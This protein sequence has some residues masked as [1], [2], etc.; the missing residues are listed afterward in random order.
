MRKDE[1]LNRILFSSL[2]VSYAY[3]LL[4][5]IPYIKPEGKGP[6]WVLI[7]M[8][9]VNVGIWVAKLYYEHQG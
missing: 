8:G 7:G 9:L 2:T 5:R 6:G 4:P 1:L 3:M